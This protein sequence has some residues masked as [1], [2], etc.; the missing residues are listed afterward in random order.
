MIRSPRRR[1]VAIAA[2]GVL[3]VSALA[4]CRTDAGTAAWV[5][6]TRISDDQVDTIA[7]SIP[8]KVLDP[9]SARVFTMTELV[10][11]EAAARYAKSKGIAAP[12]VTDTTRST[13]AQQLGIANDPNKFPVVALHA[14]TNEW[15]ALLLAQQPS[16]APSDADLQALFNELKVDFPPGT[17]FDQARQTLL[18]V[19]NL[20]Q[21]VSLRN[22]MTP[23]LKSD[24]IQISPRYANNCTKAPCPAPAVPLAYVTTS[25]GTQIN[26]V[27]LPLTSSNASP[28]AIDLPATTSN[29]AAPTQ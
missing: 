11:N 18:Q 5:G 3:A 15:L 20:P 13:V 9:A 12:A 4:A 21:A 29:T 28:A 8:S 27:V 23:S 22:S 7:E 14:M 19:P 16:T 2:L 17:T 1:L 10:F 24:N 6:N 25:D 26:V